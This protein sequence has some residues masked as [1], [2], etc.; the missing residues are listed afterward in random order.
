MGCKASRD[1]RRLSRGFPEFGRGTRHDASRCLDMIRTALIAM[2]ILPAVAMPVFA[3]TAT[4]NPGAAGTATT[5][6]GFPTTGGAV[7]LPAISTSSATTGSP[8]TPGSTAATTTG[9]T[10]AASGTTSTSTSTSTATSGA[11]GG[12]STGGGGGAR[13]STT[14]SSGGAATTGGGRS[15]SGSGTGT[16][17]VICPPSGASGLAPLFTGTDL[18]CAPD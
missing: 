12:A 1:P 2:A 18:S 4:S 16:N 3:Q 9:P 13:G 14:N 15:S 11:A 8:A 10:A 17:W 5:R 6:N 7:S